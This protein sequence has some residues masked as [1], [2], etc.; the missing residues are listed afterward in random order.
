MGMLSLEES[1]MKLIIL[2]RNKAACDCWVD[3]NTNG[4]FRCDTRQVT[5]RLRRANASLLPLL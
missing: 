5:L 3:K 1:Q 2:L 4:T